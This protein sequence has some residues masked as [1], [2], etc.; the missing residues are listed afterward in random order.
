MLPQGRDLPPG[1]LVSS[2]AVSIVVVLIALYGVHLQSEESTR[3]SLA[4]TAANE[5]SLEVSQ[6]LA[7]Y[8]TDGARTVLAACTCQD[9]V[10]T[11]IADGDNG[12]SRLKQHMKLFHPVEASTPW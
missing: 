5:M 10:D 2:Y 3:S 11:V 9:Q 6:K 4:A 7:V 8:D 1:D 12:V